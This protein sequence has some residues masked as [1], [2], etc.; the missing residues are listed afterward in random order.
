MD[1]D[2][3]P[4]ST[5]YSYPD[6]LAALSTA[7][8][9]PGQS[10][11]LLLIDL[12]DPH[13][14]QAQLGFQASARLLSGLA[15]SFADALGERAT[16]LRIGDTSCCV[17]VD[18]V[19]NGGHA[20]LAAE[21]LGRIADAALLEAGI[22]A[23]ASLSIGIALYP[24]DAGEADGLLRKAQLASMEAR[25]LGVRTVVYNDGCAGQVLQ[26]AQ[27][28]A[29]FKEALQVGALSVF[30]QPKIRISD[31]AVAGVEALMRWFDEGKPVATPDVFIPLAE[32]AGVIHDTTWYS[33]GN[34]L[35]MSAEFGQLPVAVNVTPGMLHHN[36]FIEMISAAMRTFN[37]PPQVLT[38]ELTEGAL[39]SDFE[40]ATRRLRQVRELGV[41]V[42]I[43]DF[44]TGYSSLSYFK[45]VPADEIKIDK[46]FV[47]RMLQDRA[48]QRLV[49]VIV[50]LAQ[51]FDLEVVAEGV[52][53]AATLEALAAMGCDY[54]QGYHFS[55]ALDVSRLQ[56][57]ITTYSK[58]TRARQAILGPA[59]TA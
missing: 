30:F 45:R 3:N 51:Q 14:V 7:M 17:L 26:S 42:S 15:A 58:G 49:Q 47:L 43:D 53:D 9:R 27:L 29:A 16:V 21:K 46:S 12:Q 52:E 28:S 13:Q 50:N 41:R 56:T 31:G 2:L 20:L 40:E 6:L 32:S 10:A 36:E 54:A 24:Q 18:A 59:A 38:L 22:V 35:R 5:I 34:S 1:A 39:I 44:G 48:D 37:V 8:G 55:P 57:W 11:A 4:S 19:R 33:L 25:R 23:R